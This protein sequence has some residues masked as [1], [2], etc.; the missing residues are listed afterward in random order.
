MSLDVT[1]YME[2][3]GSS[4]SF[5]IKRYEIDYP[6]VNELRKSLR[7]IACKLD[8]E[9]EHQKKLFS[10]IFS[11][12]SS[13]Q[14]S[15]VIFDEKFYET[16]AAL[17]PSQSKIEDIWGSEISDNLLRAKD[18]A[19]DL[20]GE[21]NP[22]IDKLIESAKAAYSLG[23]KCKVFITNKDNIEL[24]IHILKKEGLNFSRED[25][26]SS[27]SEFAA[28]ETFDTLIRLGPFLSSGV[29]SCPSSILSAPRYS[30]IVQLIW[31][32][33]KDDPDFG[34]DAIIMFNERNAELIKSPVVQ[35]NIS[36]ENISYIWSKPIRSSIISE[37]NVS[38][39]DFF[40]IRPY[41]E[42]EIS[43]AVLLAIDD[44]HGILYSPRSDIVIFDPSA[45]PDERV[46]RINAADAPVGGYICRI[47]EVTTG[48]LHSNS[49]TAERSKIWKS[50]LTF[51]IENKLDQ[52]VS[53]MVQSNVTL[54][55]LP[56][57]L[58]YW[59]MPASSV[60]HAPLREEHFYA[61][62]KALEIN[63]KI[64]TPNGLVD[65]Q[66]IAWND[67]RMSRIDAIISGQELSELILK[68]VINALTAS[69]Y[70]IAAQITCGKSNIKWLITPYD[71]SHE[72]F[73]EFNQLKRVET[74]LRVPNAELM[75][76]LE[77]DFIK[78][79][80]Q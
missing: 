64:E 47:R 37:T 51:H 50:L 56:Q 45:D 77:L 59:A 43:D 73:V 11:I 54:L 70:E 15:P 2:F 48:G 35:W 39:N 52:L 5:K 53:R 31:H 16:I 1:R 18:I 74:G 28:S 33:N 79:W 55:C 80:Q 25:I 38:G 26:I 65:F 12:I 30:R 69:S 7:Q 4:S 29:G 34:D 42:G 36:S 44:F 71:N 78:Q 63:T 17:F 66:S 57:Q 21:S 62:C 10:G 8:C 20:V 49:E 40:V 32:G 76:I 27:P 67:I 68:H 58:R 41:V 22:I 75:R 6:P 23:R 24:I 61:L 19:Y 13:L 60:I 3:L 72:I 9:N 14:L 46:S